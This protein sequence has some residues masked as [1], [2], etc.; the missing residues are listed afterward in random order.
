MNA[1]F[2]SGKD[3]QLTIPKET[4]SSFYAKNAQSKR[5]DFTADKVEQ[6]GSLEFTL[7]NA[8]TSNYWIQLLDSSDKV[9][10]QRYTKG[11]K[12]KFD[13]LRPEEYVVRILVDNNNDKYWDEADFSTETFAEDAYVFYKKA[14]VRALWETREEWDLKDTRT[15]DNPKG[16]PPPAPVTP[17]ASEEKRKLYFRKIKRTEI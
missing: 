15:L 13:I 2:I 3:Y 12:V 17:P 9:I 4:V 14:L 10:Y 8:P 5:F 1:D 7:L 16:T 11:D 6:F